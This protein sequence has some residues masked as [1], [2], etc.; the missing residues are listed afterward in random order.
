MPPSEREV[1]FAKQKTEGECE[2]SLF[3]NLQVLRVRKD[4]CT[5]APSPDTV[6]SSLPEG[7]YGKCVASAKIA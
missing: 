7:A 2:S 1:D 5:L 4:G 3:F 6:G